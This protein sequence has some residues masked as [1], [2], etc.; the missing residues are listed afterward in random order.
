MAYG[1]SAVLPLQ[2]ND[3]DGYYALTKTLAENIKQNFKNLLLTSP[4][5]RVMLPDFG[6]GMR[7]YLFNVPAEAQTDIE[8]QI[9][10]RITD[11]LKQYMPFVEVVNI[12]FFEEN[13]LLT[14]D[15]NALEMKIHYIIPQIS[16]S[17]VIT[18]PK[19]QIF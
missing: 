1:Y 15:E 12:D 4:G 10:S 14:G 5:E 2:K 16:T 7:N 6:V 9:Y 11:Q 8:T 13:P 17:D 18:V 19:T 3:E